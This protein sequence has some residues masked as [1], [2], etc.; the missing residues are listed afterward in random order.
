MAAHTLRW[1]PCLRCTLIGFFTLITVILV[2]WF[3]FPPRLC[4][5]LEA[6]L[7]A[8]ERLFH[9]FIIAGVFS[10]STQPEITD[11]FHCLQRRVSYIRERHLRNALRP[12]F[13][14]W[15]ILS[16]YSIPILRCLFEMKVLKNRIEV[17]QEIRRR[18]LIDDS[19][20][21]VGA[22]SCSP[23][24]I[25]TFPV[26][27]VHLLSFRSALSTLLVCTYYQATRAYMDFIYLQL[28]SDSHWIS[29]GLKGK[30]CNFISQPDLSHND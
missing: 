29:L 1:L 10:P 20:V 14:I 6:N 3:A 19:L 21:N 5:T 23:P 11:V 8:T 15:D 26:I 17:L 4:K 27:Y 24:I 28:G 2:L 12:W 7:E 16:G 30:H 18:E 25:A 13:N 22:S 9:G